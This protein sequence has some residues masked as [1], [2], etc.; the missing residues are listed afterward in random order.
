MNPMKP[1]QHGITKRF[2]KASSHRPTHL[3]VYKYFI[4]SAI[5][6]ISARRQCKTKSLKPMHKS[7]PLAQIELCWYQKHRCI[8][9][10]MGNE[11]IAIYF[12]TSN[13]LSIQILRNTLIDSSLLSGSHSLFVVP[14]RMELLWMRSILYFDNPYVILYS[15]TKNKIEPGHNFSHTTKRRPLMSPYQCA[16]QL[17]RFKDL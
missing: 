14:L 8:K 11:K 6:W 13:W 10:S 2:G 9:T 15:D 5:L 4:S 7:L 1:N 3:L 17:R 12:S 16:G